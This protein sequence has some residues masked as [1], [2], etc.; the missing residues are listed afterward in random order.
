MLVTSLSHEY[1][2]SLQQILTSMDPH[3]VI[4]SI[5]LYIFFRR[6]SEGHV[7]NLEVDKAALNSEVYNLRCVTY[8]C[9]L[10]Y[11]MH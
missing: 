11:K 9:Q 6:I 8:E 4:S 2:T 5:S 10:P 7:H 1:P 3:G